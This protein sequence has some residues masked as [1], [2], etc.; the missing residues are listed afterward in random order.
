MQ[1]FFYLDLE[2]CGGMIYNFKTFSRAGI[3]ECLHG[4]VEG[5]ERYVRS[6]LSVNECVSEGVV[7]FR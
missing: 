6:C 2:F 7:K 3:T 1:R 5:F 4:F